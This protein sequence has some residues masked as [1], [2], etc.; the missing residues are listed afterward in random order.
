MADSNCRATVDCQFTCYGADAGNSGQ[1]CA[2]A[3]AGTTKAIFVAYQN[4]QE[5]G[6][7][8]GG[9]TPPCACP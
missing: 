2:N 1:T 5:N 8:G 9:T 6:T 3:C 7:C 4:C